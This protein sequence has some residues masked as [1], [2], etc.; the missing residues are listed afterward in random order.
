MKLLN[1]Q[2]TE[3]TVVQAT[4]NPGKLCKLACDHTM[5]AEPETGK[6]ASKSLLKFLVK[7]EHTSVL[8][9]CVM[10]FAIKGVSRSLMAQ[11]T[12][13]RVSSPTCQSQHYQDYSEA[14]MVINESYFNRNSVLYSEALTKS[15]GYYKELLANSETKE[16][17]RQVLPNAAA[18]NILWTVNARELM[19]FLRQRLCRRNVEEMYVFAHSILLEC[20][21]WWPELFEFAG[22]PCAMDGKCNQGRMRSPLCK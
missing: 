20:F 4:N 1:Y 13:S 12:R 14:P 22:A 17:A 18:V 15:L 7:A 5:V 11:V 21:R 10:T 19:L 6:E 9:H 2:D 16:E 8:E 3:I